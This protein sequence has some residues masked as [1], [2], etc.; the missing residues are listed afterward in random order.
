ML[1]QDNFLKDLHP[2]AMSTISLY[3]E[4]KVGDDLALPQ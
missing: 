1:T 3:S 4:R 2:I